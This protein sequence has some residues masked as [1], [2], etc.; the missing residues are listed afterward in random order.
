MGSVPYCSGSV[1]YCSLLIMNDTDLYQD[2]RTSIVEFLRVIDEINGMDF[3]VYTSKRTQLLVSSLNVLESNN[4]AEIISVAEELM[5]S[6][7]RWYDG[8]FKRH[9]EYEDERQKA[10]V[11]S[12]FQ[13]AVKYLAKHGDEQQMQRAKFYLEESPKN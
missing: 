7:Y 4:R 3:D 1:P 9:T 6:I 12:V 2:F 13:S 10:E 11:L 5:K 8:G